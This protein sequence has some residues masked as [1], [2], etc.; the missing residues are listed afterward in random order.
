MAGDVP[1][2]G[3]Q[4]AGS[5]ILRSDRSA[6]LVEVASRLV[7][8][9]GERGWTGDNELAVELGHYV[10]GT[11]SDLVALQVELDQ[12]GDVL[13]ESGGSGS[14][15]DIVEG[16]V[17]PGQLFDVDQGPADFDEDSDRWMRV[18]GLE[19]RSAYATMERFVATIE[20]ED[21]VERLTDALSRSGP[22]QRFRT[23]LSRYEAE[24]TNWHRFHDDAQLGRARAWLADQGYKSDH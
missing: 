17:W 8:A 7:V 10:S 1:V 5:A 14:Y 21:I 15:L 24:Y 3:L 13:D 20:N 18:Q 2:N 4:H 19:S 9:L 11:S 16:T 6:A 12:L 22:F 23:E